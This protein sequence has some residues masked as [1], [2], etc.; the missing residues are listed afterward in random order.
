MFA[1][2]YSYTSAFPNEMLVTEAIIIWYL[3]DKHKIDW[4]L[5][6]L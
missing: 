5:F 4:F 2:I 6:S 1:N 3:F